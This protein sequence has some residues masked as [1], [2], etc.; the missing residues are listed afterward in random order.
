MTR[1]VEKSDRLTV[2]LHT[3]GAYMLGDPARLAGGDAALANCV[4]KRG[5]AVIDMAHECDN[6]RARLKSFFLRFFGFLGSL[7]LDFLFVVSLRGVLLFPLENEAM[8]VTELRDRIEFQGL[9]D[10][11]KD[12]KRHQIG[13][14]LKGF[15]PD[16]RSEI[17]DRNRRFEMNHLLAG[18]GSDSLRFLG[19]RLNRS[20]LWLRRLRGL[21]DDDGA[22]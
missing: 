8:L 17:L 6:G 22:L 12:L 20:F 1:R 10:V 5:L 18:L 19:G 4:E 7:D 3:V 2:A 21:F 13:N 15:D 14:D 11:S 16:E 9:I